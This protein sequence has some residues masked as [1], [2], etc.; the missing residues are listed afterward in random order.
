MSCRPT[1][2]GS[3]AW[4][5]PGRWSRRWTRSTSGTPG[6]P[7]NNARLWRWPRC[8]SN[9]GRAVERSAAQQLGLLEGGP[10]AV[11]VEHRTGQAARCVAGQEHDQLGDLLRRLQAGGVALGEAGL[12]V[13]GAED[14]RIH[15]RVDVARADGV[16]ADV[17]QPAADGHR[18]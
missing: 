11:A 10:A 5:S 16:D 14:D 3:P 7:R 9:A 8:S 6:S 15:R 18:L 4:W 13:A 1:T 17:Q 2:S 12:Q